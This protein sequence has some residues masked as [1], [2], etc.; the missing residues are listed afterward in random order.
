MMIPVR[1]ESDYKILQRLRQSCRMALERYVDIAS[2]SSGQLA[3]MTPGAVDQ[4]GRAN[5]ALLRQKEQRAHEAY[6]EARSALLEYVLAGCRPL[7]S[8]LQ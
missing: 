5:L 2:H 8:S 7:E 4:V 6:L 3:C 1:P